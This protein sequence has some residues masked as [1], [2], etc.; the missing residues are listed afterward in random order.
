M[1]TRTETALPGGLAP[2]IRAESAAPEEA[3]HLRN[4]FIQL[5]GMAEG[6]AN[7]GGDGDSFTAT[8]LIVVSSLIETLQREVANARGATVDRSDADQRQEVCAA[9]WSIVRVA[10]AASLLTSR[11]QRHVLE[12]LSRRLCP[13]WEEDLCAPDD[14]AGPIKRRSAFYLQ[15]VDSQD[16]VTAAVRIVALLLEAAEIEPAQRDIRTRVLAG[17]IAH[18]IVSDVWLFNA[19]EA[20]GRLGPPTGGKS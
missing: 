3:G 11:Q 15:R 12:V 9:V 18:R 17:L 20:E 16:P 2:A 6:S 1:A 19:W 10:L 4:A 13:R 7:N 5:A 14:N 8:Y